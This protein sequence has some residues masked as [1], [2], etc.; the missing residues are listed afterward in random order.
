MRNL[1]ALLAALLSSPAAA[2]RFTNPVLGLS[3]E[4]PHDWHVV[5]AAEN[6]ENLSKAEFADPELQ[7]AVRK[8]ASVPLYAFSRYPEPYPDLNASV[9][10]NTRP[11][12]QFEG[13]SGENVL[14]AILPAISQAMPDA[15]IVAPPETTTLAGRAAGHAVMTYTLRSEGKAYPAV[16]E[17]WII[18]R[19]DYL[20]MVGAGYRP[21]ET[22]GDRLAVHQ[23]VGS[24]QLKD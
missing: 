10:V 8:Y 16:S 7:A 21:D 12:G 5:T 23:I 2:E 11:A 18:P 15:K 14:Q 22:T 9:K 3:I 13:Q 6:S 1:L 19:G 4:N 24:L 17:L 20:V